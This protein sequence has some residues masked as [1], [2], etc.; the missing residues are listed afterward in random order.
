MGEDFLTRLSAVERGVPT[1]PPRV[2]TPR[3]TPSRAHSGAASQPHA[4]PPQ[5]HDPD[6]LQLRG[7]TP[8]SR[9]S[10]R[11]SSRSPTRG[12]LRRARTSGR[13]GHSDDHSKM[14]ELLELVPEADM[15][16][17]VATLEKCGYDVA[18]AAELLATKIELQ[19]QSS[20]DPSR[21]IDHFDDKVRNMQ[22]RLPNADAG[23]LIQALVEKKGHAGKALYLVEQEVGKA[24]RIK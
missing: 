22:R 18:M 23:R 16:S 13:F 2:A 1:P 7:R 21:A 9:T 14:R 3:E 15:E 12:V 19:I 6:T 5:S 8:D 20:L 24:S 11:T 4:P 10:S 17:A